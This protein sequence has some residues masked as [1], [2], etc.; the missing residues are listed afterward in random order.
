MGWLLLIPK[1]L[2]GVDSVRQLGGKRTS[3]PKQ[4]AEVLLLFEAQPVGKA[5]FNYFKTRNKT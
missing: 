1:Q 5:S 2:V 4:L 3:L